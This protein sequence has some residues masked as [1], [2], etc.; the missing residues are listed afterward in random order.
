MDTGE[1]G[2][3]TDPASLIGLTLEALYVQFGVPE[4]VYAV[5]GLEAWQDDVV[6][7]YDRG[8]FYVYKNRVWQLGVKNAYGIALGEK[9]PAVSLLAGE[10]AQDFEDYI[11]V[12]L[13]SRGW[14]LMLRIN[15]DGSTVTNATV[16]AIFIYRP[17]F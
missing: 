7:V 11:L 16:S 17:D 15:F 8:D 6:F 10:D 3:M 12:A 4:A 2:D 5:R 13:P 9:R 1:V 14:P